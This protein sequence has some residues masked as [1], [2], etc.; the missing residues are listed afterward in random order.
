[1]KNS[2]IRNVANKITFL[3]GLLY[4]NLAWASDDPFSKVTEKGDEFI[5]YLTGGLAVMF[6]TI[7]VG[8]SGYA[9]SQ[10]KLRPER[11]WQI[12]IGGFMVSCSATLAA[13][14][15]A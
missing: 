5:K 10:G 2:T 8:I 14:I 15:F 4:C 7:V 13:W 12:I 3:T 1:M 9:M 6:F 11:G